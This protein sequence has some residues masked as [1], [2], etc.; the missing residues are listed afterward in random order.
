MTIIIGASAE[1]A[2]PN[3]LSQAD[4]D[5]PH[6]AS[7]PA[8]QRVLST[9]QIIELLGHELALVR[10]FAIEQVANDSLPELIEAL[11]PLL[12]DEDDAVAAEAVAVLDKERY[13]AATEAVRTAFAESKG[14]RTVALAGALATLAPD[15]LL[16]A[17]QAK[18]RIDT[19]AY[20][21]V[22]SALAITASEPVIRFFDKALNRS[23]ALTAERRSALFTAVLLAGDPALA[24]R[25]LTKAVSDSKQEEPESASFPSRV[26]LG[27]IAGIPLASTRTEAGDEL[28]KQVRAQ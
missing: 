21:A 13:H 8:D 24:T 17:V 26:A 7:V 22:L 19:E 27:T 2:A 4:V 11:V 14:A 23:G 9:E 1:P 5:F 16:E 15:T 12:R 28:F 3:P 20:G 10:S 6:P 25:V 18:G